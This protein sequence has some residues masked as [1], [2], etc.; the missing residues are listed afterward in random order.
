MLNSSVLA[1]FKT[2][3]FRVCGTVPRNYPVNDL[4]DKQLK[5]TYSCN[6]ERTSSEIYLVWKAV[7]RKFYNYVIFQFF[8]DVLILTIDCSEFCE[9]CLKKAHVMYTYIFSAIPKMRYFPQ[10]WKTNVIMILKYCKSLTDPESCRP[11]SL[12]KPFFK[13]LI[14]L[15]LHF[16]VLP[17]PWLMFSGKHSTFA[18]SLK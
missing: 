4:L 1:N 13:H 8:C 12:L 17:E 16:D 11:I 7:V 10:H 6:R 3:T 2:I 9:K 5:Y 15:I 14:T 18:H